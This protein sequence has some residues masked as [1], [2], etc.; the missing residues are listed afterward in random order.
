MSASGRTK[1]MAAGGKKSAGFTI[2]ETIIVL[3]V[4]AG[5]AASA[6]LLVSG[7]QNKTQFQVAANNF[8]QQLEQIINE[9]ANGFYPSNNDFQCDGTGATPVISTGTNK[10]G[11]NSSCIFLGKAMAFGI[12]STGAKADAFTALPLVAKRFK[13]G[14]TTDVATFADARPTALASGNNVGHQTG[15]VEKGVNYT[16]ANGLSL[17]YSRTPTTVSTTA[18]KT[19]AVL[20]FAYD[21]T[22]YAPAADGTLNSAVQKL[23]LYSYD[24]NSTWPAGV[25]AGMKAVVDN[26]DNTVDLAT[27]YTDLITGKAAVVTSVELCYASGGTN[28]S[29]R[30]VISGQGQ[31]S[32]T[33]TIFYSGNCT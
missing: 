12:G 4:S 15:G 23:N 19:Y 14:T 20:A 5:L 13:A 9:T 22:D 16:T 2:V 6:L 25:P 10:Q 32:V 27:P 17:V 28:Q 8:K 3:A 29:A 26:I 1:T 31:L 33:M 7:K 18:S 11:T 30:Y 24:I 21:L